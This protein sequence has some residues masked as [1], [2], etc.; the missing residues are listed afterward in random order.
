LLLGGGN[1]KRG[2]Y[3]YDPAYIQFEICE[4]MLTDKEYYNKVFAVASEYCAE[5][6]HVHAIDVN[7]IVGHCEAYRLGYGSNHADP[8]HWM[9]NFGENMDDFRNRVSNILKSNDEKK[10]NKGEIVSKNTSIEKGDLV[11]ISDNATYYSGQAIPQWVS[12]QKWYVKSITNGDRVVIDKN[13]NGTSSICSPI[14]KKYLTIV[15]KINVPE[16]SSA[17][18]NVKLNVCPYLVKVTTDCLWIRKEADNN[19]AKVGSITD[20]GVY[21]IVQEKQGSGASLW[22]RLKSGVGWISLDYVKKI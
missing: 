8:E 1:G 7:N 2:S 12:A 15:E 10:E 5:L 4:D 16:A 19:T 6:C 21:T 9:K 20:Q 13:E 14:N 22:G 3:N 18:T 11:A 17:T